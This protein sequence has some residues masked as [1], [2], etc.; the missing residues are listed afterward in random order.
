[1]MK[2][3][4]I[5]LAGFFF[6]APAQAQDMDYHD[7][8]SLP[9]LHDGRIQPLDSFARH[10][11]LTFSGSERFDGKPAI[12]WLAN[13]LFDPGHAAE[14]KIFTI[15]NPQALDL[16]D[17]QRELN[18]IELSAALTRQAP[19]LDILLKTD[20]ADWNADQ[21]A[22]M[23]YQEYALLYGELLRS[24]TVMLPLNVSPPETLNI[25]GDNLTYADLSSHAGVIR[26]HVK[27]IVARKGDDPGRYTE[28]E[29]D[30]VTFAYQLDLLGR[31]SEHNALLKIIPAGAQWIAPW[32]VAE[33]NPVMTHWQ[34]L[35]GAWHKD[36]AALWEETAE[37]MA[38]EQATP[39][40][41]AE[42]LYNQAHP[43]GL[44]MILYLA[45]F[46]CASLFAIFTK[47]FL[48]YAAHNLML[49]AIAA[50][51]IAIGLRVFILDRP[52][53]GTLYESI[54]FVALIAALGG[55]AFARK[56]RRAQG[57]M[58]GALAGGLL[59]FIAEAF[60]TDDTMRVLVA[61]LN[62]NFWLATHVLCITIGYGWCILTGLFAHFYL[63]A[64]AGGRLTAVQHVRLTQTIKSLALIAL[65]FTTIGTILG[66]IWA[67]QSWGRFWGW[68]PK[69]NG[70]LLIVLWLSWCLHGSIAG[71][72]KSLSFMASLAALNMIVALA[73][74]GVNLLNTGLHSYGF[75]EGVAAALA[76]FIAAEVLIITSLWITAI[77]R[78]RQTA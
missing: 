40:L 21:K 66:G 3:I 2:Y 17:H 67:D 42:V 49:S 31:A 70:A 26:G 71:Q 44:S 10:Y 45:A 60:A 34:T 35:A 68:D 9:V 72:L 8:K 15:H 48:H 5:L 1:M 76:A 33:G 12:G 74:F 23:Q 58:A 78:D 55:L 62:T 41:T 4:L 46:L 16:V 63:I 77:Y 25:A 19:A 52:P 28:E 73:W 6:S 53:V 75:I 47:P 69:E 51:A 20:P 29:Q 61:V 27:D 36:D 39:R 13:T 59:L 14:D 64:R 18:Y 7:F 37:T 11:L 50:N 32:M 24:L 56:G 54:I 57:L 22:L 30:I 43:L 65:L 38:V